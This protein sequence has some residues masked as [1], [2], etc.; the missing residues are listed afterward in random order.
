M[1]STEQTPTITLLTL[2]HQYTALH[3]SATTNLKDT[4]WNLTKARQKRGFQAGGGG[5]GGLEYSVQD[6]REDLRALVVLD[7]ENRLHFDGVKSLR[8]Q[9]S[10]DLGK[11]ETD[12]LRRRGGNASSEDTKQE[13]EKWT[14][15]ILDGEEKLRLADPLTLFGVPPASLRAAQARSRDAIAYYV[16]VAILAQEILSITNGTSDNID[17]RRKR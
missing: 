3:S 13:S 17:R 6:V 1:E 10:I 15:E 7:E 14:E 11:K 5:F 4:Y 12:G 16:E 8:E 2:L 9:S